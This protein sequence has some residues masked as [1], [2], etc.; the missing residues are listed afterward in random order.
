MAVPSERAGRLEPYTRSTALAAGWQWRIP[1]QHRT[2]NGYVY[3]SEFLSDDAAAAA[4][5]GN[6]D[7]KALADPRPIRFRTGCRRA[8]WNKNVIA[9]GLSGGF[10][11]P[12]E[13]TS[14][15]LIQS[16]IAKLLSL[17]P[18]RDCHSH[19]VAQYNRLVADEFTGVRDFLVLHYHS[20]RERTEPLWEYCRSMPLPASLIDKERHFAHSGRIVLSPEELFREPSWFAVLLGQGHRPGD[21]NPLIDSI[22]ST[23]NLAHLKRIREEIRFAAAKMPD[24]VSYFS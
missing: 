14:I 22:A 18:N 3:S 19:L 4:L 5:L 6:L 2:G 9:I 10:L 24:H 21:Y 13:S 17:F 8:A 11:E 16:G 7:G 1:L 15:H 12:L 20:T 23:D